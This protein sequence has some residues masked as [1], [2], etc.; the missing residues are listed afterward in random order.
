M[1]KKTTRPNLPQETL[2]RARRELAQSGVIIDEPVRPVEAAPGMA[3][4]P[5]AV[6]RPRHPVTQADLRA[7]YA[8]VAHDLRSMAI[9]ASLFMIVLVGLSFFI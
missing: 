7:E 2:E 1:A 3:A 4:A 5:V 8:Y 6:V 9:L